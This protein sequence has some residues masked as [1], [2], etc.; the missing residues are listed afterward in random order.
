[1]EV[2][3][4][5]TADQ[6]VEDG[7]L[8]DVPEET[9]K[10]A[11][12]KFKVRLTQGVVQLCTPDEGPEDFNGRVWDVLNVLRYAIQA[13]PSGERMVTFDVTFSGQKH[14]LWGCLDGTSGP[15][16]HVMTPSEY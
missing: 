4:T 11:G 14:R 1:M 10:E 15:A 12:F 8:W 9:V 6:A 5:Y 13:E 16:I 3:Y 2:I 7:I